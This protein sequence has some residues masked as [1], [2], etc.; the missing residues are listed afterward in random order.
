MTTMKQY[1]LLKLV[2]PIF[3]ILFAV[4]ISAQDIRSAYFVKGTSLAHRANPAFASEYNYVSFP[5]LGNMYINTQTNVGLSTFLYS[6]DNSQYGL[7]TFLNE[8]VNGKTFLGK[9]NDNNKF[10]IGLNTTILSAGFHAWGGFNTVEVGL[11]S[12]VSLNLPYDLFD[13]LKSGMK[14]ET[15]NK[16]DVKDLSVRSNNYVELA[17]G[18]ARPID[19]YL[20]VGAKVKGLIGVANLDVKFDK[21]SITMNKDKWIITADGTLDAAIKGGQF[22]T[23]PFDTD[24]KKEGEITGFK[25]NS[26]G[27]GGFGVGIDLGATYDLGVF[28]ESFGIDSPWA[29]NITV[30]AAI[31]DLG[32]ISWSNSLKGRTDGVPF[33]FKGFKDIKVVSDD[34]ET[35][36]GESMD[37]QLDGITEDLEALIKFYD[38]GKGPRTTSLATT[39]NLGAEYIFP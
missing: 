27:I 23:E 8:S 16:Y 22:E 33:E 1:I 15:G 7:T 13:F 14:K 38:N 34:S 32:F 25:L 10:D 26:P 28:L 30:S 37:D 11:K 21:M 24:T 31:L 18:H 2:F 35:K 4:G 9:L 12:N 3:C 6:S 36:E 29:E 39:V 20:V 19:D 5:I 17:L